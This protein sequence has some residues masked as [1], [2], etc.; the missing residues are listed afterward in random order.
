MVLNLSIYASFIRVCEGLGSHNITMSESQ[1]YDFE[2]K[3][4][5]FRGT[6]PPEAQKY[7]CHDN[8]HNSI[9]P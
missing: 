4:H 7:F 5:S 6:T 3:G 8:V 9:G 2:V 1:G